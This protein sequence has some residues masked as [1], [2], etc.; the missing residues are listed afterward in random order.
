MI[1]REKG[2]RHIET[3]RDPAVTPLRKG[4]ATSN[5]RSRVSCGVTNLQSS[6]G[7]TELIKFAKKMGRRLANKPTKCNNWFHCVVPSTKRGE[8]NPQPGPPARSPSLG[9]PNPEQEQAT[10]EA[11][12]N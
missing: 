9:E 7:S 6:T 11:N 2:K 5:V 1:A 12:P 8:A 10:S 4:K 3:P